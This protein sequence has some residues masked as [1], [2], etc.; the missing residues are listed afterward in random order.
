MPQQPNSKARSPALIRATRN[1]EAGTPQAAKIV[2]RI[3]WEL[4][5][6]KRS[7]KYYIYNKGGFYG[8]I[9]ARSDKNGLI[10]FVLYQK[11]HKTKRLKF[12]RSK[13][14]N[15]ERP[16]FITAPSIWAHM[17]GHG[18][19]HLERAE[20]PF[21]KNKLEQAAGLTEEKQIQLSP[22]KSRAPYPLPFMPSPDDDA[23]QVQRRWAQFAGILEKRLNRNYRQSIYCV[24]QFFVE[25]WKE[26][27]KISKTGAPCLVKAT[28][29]YLGQRFHT[30]RHAIRRAIMDLDRLGMIQAAL[31]EP[32]GV[33]NKRGIYS[34]FPGR[35]IPRQ[36]PTRH[37][38]VTLHETMHCVRMFIYAGRRV[39][40]GESRSTWSGVNK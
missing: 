10:V 31:Y 9:I 24:W 14:P 26:S 33:K 16:I 37:W 8:H 13:V 25:R 35:G 34:Y 23:E 5:P 19:L 28:D 21:W 3:L 12:R 29:G 6:V 22:K 1:Y 20:Y 30:S 2:D 40:N 18:G 11:P 27:A 39:A 32:S 7:S 4:T 15:A 17:H 38:K 36:Q